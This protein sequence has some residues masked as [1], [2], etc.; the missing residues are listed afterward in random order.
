[1]VFAKCFPA[2]RG[3]KN[4]GIPGLAYLA[5]FGAFLAFAGGGVSGGDAQFHFREALAAFAE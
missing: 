3:A 1:M 2:G 4:G 5:R